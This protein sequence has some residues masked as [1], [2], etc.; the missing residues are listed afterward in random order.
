M[1]ISNALIE[2]LGKED[3]KYSMIACLLGSYNISYC[4]LSM[5]LFEMS[6]SSI[7]GMRTTSMI[8]EFL[9]WFIL[10]ITYATV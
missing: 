5:I 10:H 1:M 9:G 6:L 8:A 2:H 7:S 3:N 4:V